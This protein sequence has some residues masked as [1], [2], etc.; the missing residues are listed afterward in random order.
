MTHY[1]IYCKGDILLTEEGNVPFGIEP[2]IRLQPW[3]HVTTISSRGEEYE[4]ARIDSPYTGGNGYRMFGLRSTYNILNSE[5]YA[6]AGKGAELAYWDYNTRHCGVCGSPM[7]WNSPISKRCVQCNKEIWPSPSTAI[8]V[9]ITR[10]DKILLVRANSFRG[11]FYGLVAGFVETGEN[12]EQCVRREVM[13]ETGLEISNIQYFDSQAWPYPYGL[14]IGF[15]AEYAKGEIRLQK[16]ELCQGAWF[17]RDNLPN[18]PDK[19]SIARRLIDDWI[20]KG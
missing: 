14:M 6:I 18:I 20:R 5:D 9:R 13:E 12:L 11:D 4:I 7:K 3:N 19:A 10:D 17:T 16:S 8:I 1:L 15:T 2:P